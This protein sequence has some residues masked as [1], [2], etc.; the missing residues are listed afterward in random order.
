[1]SR[2]A[3]PAERPIFMIVNGE[4]FAGAERQILTL[5]LGLQ[6]THPVTLI[7]LCDRE[8]VIRARGAGANVITL[9]T[10]RVIDLPA[11]RKLRSLLL[12]EPSAILHVHGYR[13][14]AYC[15]AALRGKPRDAVKTEH[16]APELPPNGFVSRL[17]GRLFNWLDKISTRQLNA[18]CVYVTADLEGVFRS[19]GVARRVVIRN[20]LD[21]SGLEEK[22]A[23]SPY[24]P[25]SFPV[26][27][28]GRL[29]HV[30]GID[31]AIRAIAN[32]QIPQITL[33]VVGSGPMLQEYRELAQ[34]LGVADRVIFH[35]AQDNPYRYIA[36]A[37]ALLMSSRH[38]GLPYV[39]LEALCLKTPIVAS[40]VGGLSEVL[41]HGETALLCPATDHFAF[42]AAI[43]SLYHSN[44]LPVRLAGNGSA[45]LHQQ[46]SAGRMIKEYEEL[47]AKLSDRT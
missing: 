32:L 3:S 11:I 39:V 41:V 31:V 33:H 10:Q 12:S 8:F 14:A 2:S 29:E 26:V 13:A 23:G 9:A 28:V 18:T 38:E 21:T 44:E 47:Y 15:A 22:A 42:A 16:G 1:M 19:W 36:H 43:S 45:L 7:A 25:E 20:G 17:K 40:A 6:N 24:L 34:S 4:V 27:I 35:G 37:K 46:F 5:V 30:K